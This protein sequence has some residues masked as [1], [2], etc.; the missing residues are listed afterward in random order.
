[1]IKQFFPL[2][3]NQV[4]ANVQPFFKFI[5]IILLS[6]QISS[7]IYP[8]GRWERIQS[9]TTNFLRK[10][11]VSD[12]N[13]IWAAGHQGTLIKSTDRGNSWNVV[14][15]NTTNTIMNISAVN[16][17][18]IF[19][20]TWEFELPPYGTYILKST[21]GGLNWQKQFF[22]I[23]FEFLQSIHFF[24]ETVG[25]VAGTKTY[26]TSNGGQSWTLA[27]R[28]SDI[29]AN[30]PFLNIKMLNNNYGFACGGFLDVAG[31][32]WKTTN[33]G[34][35]WKTNGISPDEIFDMVVFDSLNVIALSGDP[36]FIYNLAVVK[37]TDG[38]ETWTY[39]EL[40]TYAVSLGID[41][42]SRNEIWSAAGYKF[43]YSTDGGDTWLERTTPD[44]TSIYD[45][46]FINNQLGFACGDN[47]VLLKYTESGSSVDAENPDLIQFTLFQN[48]PNPFFISSD[49]SKTII[50]F[51]ISNNDFESNEKRILYNGK[52]GIQVTLKIFD[53]LGRD[54]ATLV[55][56]VKLPG[57]YE[58]TFPSHNGKILSEL[59]AG[60]YF[61]Q[62]MVGN[63][64]ET[65]KMLLLK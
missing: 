25:I 23:E 21:N 48:Y 52:S 45:L 49:N 6:I 11:V 7:A 5:T 46:V 17:Q 1:M 54:V 63:R 22:P 42:K 2:I 50:K 30:L 34:L 28:D 41:A 62:L 29:V 61:Y 18:L 35:N 39:T 4:T 24:S 53:I 32:I 58:Y 27:Q 12:S 65:R 40:P 8:Q 59:S 26:L 3:S 60:I 57:V 14:A 37:T 9:P 38:G 15:T 33:G 43:I 36:E 47:G 10:I 51:S 16:S 19:L 55:D 13:T 31:V 20:I 44:S 64:T 56:E